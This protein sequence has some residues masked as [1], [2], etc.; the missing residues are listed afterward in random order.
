MSETPSAEVSV[1]RRAALLG[2]LLAMAHVPFVGLQYLREWSLPHYQFFPFALLVY[3]VL[4]KG[5]RRP[6][7]FLPDRFTLLLIGLDILLLSAAMWLY[8][9]WVAAAGFLLLMWATCGALRDVV[10]GTNLSY[11]MLLPLITLRPPFAAD[12]TMIQSL[13]SVTT[14]ITSR[15]L[16]HF[17]YLHLRDGN[18]L[19]FPGRRFMV[20]EACSGVQ[21]LFTVLFVAVFTVCLFRRRWFHAVP[22]LLGSVVFAG[23]LNVLRITTISVAWVHRGVDLSTGWQHQLIG[24]LALAVA[25]LLVFS[26]DAF[27]RFLFAPIAPEAAEH[28]GDLYRNPIADLWNRIVTFRRIPIH[29]G[30]TVSSAKVSPIAAAITAVLCVAAIG[31][32]AMAIGSSERTSAGNDLTAPLH[33]DGNELPNTLAG[34]VRVPDGYSTERRNRQHSEGEFSSIWVFQ[35]HGLTARVALD[36]PFCGWHGLEACYLGI[37][38]QVAEQKTDHSQREWPCRIF[39]FHQPDD[40]RHG[41]LIYS[42]FDEFGQPY[43]P[44]EDDGVFGRLQNRMAGRRISPITPPTTMQSQVF[45]ETPV[46]VTDE[47]LNQLLQLHLEAR[48]TMKNLLVTVT[49]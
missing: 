39:R 31:I 5:R 32:Q 33:P 27:F 24:Y 19:T 23:I 26:A 15:L 35:Q 3:V 28:P 6:G 22:L 37:G 17:G 8:S 12:L 46:P 4:L 42:L 47:Q 44:P 30:K 10:T 16:N 20:E 18:V 7:V 13:Q 34:W 49:R 25:A 9:P 29:T 1:D 41:L 38:W 45:T 21:S 14:R 36:H 2:G 43:R 11:L 40:G 48:Q